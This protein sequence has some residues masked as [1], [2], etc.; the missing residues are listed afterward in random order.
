MALKGWGRH[1]DWKGRSTTWCARCHDLVCWKY[2]RFHYKTVASHKQV[3]MAGRE[4]EQYIKATCIPIHLQWTIWQWNLENC[5]TCST[6]KYLGINLKELSTCFVNYKKLLNVQNRQ[7]CRDRKW[8]S[9]CLM[10]R[11]KVW[12][13]WNDCWL[14]RVS[15]WGDKVWN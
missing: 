14:I 13:M 8:I 3:R 12:E 4:H 5:S 1:W 11:V 6:P 2:W 7:V 9:A 15:F 10:V